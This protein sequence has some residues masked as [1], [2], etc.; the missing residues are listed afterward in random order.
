MCVCRGLVWKWP[1]VSPPFSPFFCLLKCFALGKSSVLK[2]YSILCT[3]GVPAGWGYHI[4][5]SPS[6]SIDLSQWGLQEPCLT[7]L[8]PVTPQPF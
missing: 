8:I 7:V 6:P 2:S 4:F 3:S 5:S 1:E